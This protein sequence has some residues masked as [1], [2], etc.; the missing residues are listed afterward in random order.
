MSLHK[1]PGSAQLVTFWPTV[2]ARTMLENQSAAWSLPGESQLCREIQTCR[3]DLKGPRSTRPSRT[4]LSDDKSWQRKFLPVLV[5][6]NPQSTIT[7]LQ[8]QIQGR[9]SPLLSCHKIRNLLERINKKG[10]EEQT[11]L[12]RDSFIF[13]KSFSKWGLFT[14][15]SQERTCTFW[16]FKK[17]P[18]RPKL[19]YL[20]NL[21]AALPNHR[22]TLTVLYKPIENFGQ[23]WACIG[24]QHA[25]TLLCALK[26]A[27]LTSH[28]PHVFWGTQQYCSFA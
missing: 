25:C 23:F 21:Q 11:S 17:K 28:L 27:F 12:S 15:S 8:I 4:W 3:W 24:C 10:Q 26:I 5:Q 20:W 14:L 9:S 2:T 22:N 1:I 13:S 7:L 16:Q 6:R 18:W 19:H